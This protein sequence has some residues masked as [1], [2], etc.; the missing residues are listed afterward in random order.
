ME[1]PGSD[2]GIPFLDT[3]CYPNVDSTIHTWVF[4]KTTHTDHYLSWNSHHPLSAK[5]AVIQA[6][7][8]SAKNVSFNPEILA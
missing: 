3:K 1:A 8:Y 6:L 4:G 7:T 5:K 2:G